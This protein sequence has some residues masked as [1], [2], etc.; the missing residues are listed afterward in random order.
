MRLSL[1]YT[2]Y[3]VLI[4]IIPE[5]VVKIFNCDELELL[6]NGQPF[7]DLYDWMENTTYKG[8]SSDSDVFV[9]I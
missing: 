1:D 4:Q 8:F 7:I 3:I 6:I 9:L 2:R 5:K